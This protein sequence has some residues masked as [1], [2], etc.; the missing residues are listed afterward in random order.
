M[1]ENRTKNKRTRKRRSKTEQQKNSDSNRTAQTIKIGN[2]C[3]NVIRETRTLMYVNAT[4][5]RP[6][7]NTMLRTSRVQAVQSC[8]C[9]VYT[10]GKRAMCVG[11]RRCVPKSSIS[12]NAGDRIESRSTAHHVAAYENSLIYATKSKRTRA[13]KQTTTHTQRSQFMWR[14]WQ[15]A[16]CATMVSAIT[17]PWFRAYFVKFAWDEDHCE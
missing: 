16:G 3:N 2:N 12:V 4:C 11:M 10:R 17:S 14:V 9:D 8:T 15:R 7:H 6:V 1:G 13:N 5:I